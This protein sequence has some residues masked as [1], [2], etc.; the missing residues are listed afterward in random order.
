M[1]LLDRI[2]YLLEAVLADPIG[3]AVVLVLPVNVIFRIAHDG[4]LT[5]P[6]DSPVE[7]LVGVYTLVG[8]AIAI[9][10][11]VFR[12]VGHWAVRWQQ[13]IRRIREG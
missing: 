2:A 4:R 7:W 11:T 3:R 5:G 10:D 1:S 6:W 13:F 8:L 9:L 12:Q